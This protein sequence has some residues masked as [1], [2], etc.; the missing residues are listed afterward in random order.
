MANKKANRS[1]KGKP[2]ATVSIDSRKWNLPPQPPE[3]SQSSAPFVLQG[4]AT[5]FGLSKANNFTLNYGGV[6]AG[7][8]L[9]YSLG[10][11]ANLAIRVTHVGVYGST[12]S[13]V[14]SSQEASQY[15]I[16]LTEASSG[17]AERG[18]SDAVH[19]ARAGFVVPHLRQWKWY[20]SGNRDTIAEKDI[21]YIRAAYNSGCPEDTQQNALDIIVKGYYRIS[22]N[23]GT[24][25]T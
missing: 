20:D 24:C 25:P 13:P 5:T 19:R 18:V 16:T 14:T 3:T 6:V 1:K 4:N 10:T 8:R 15:I 23:I 7:L 12:S 17:R 2:S 22:R 9:T 11:D 21:A